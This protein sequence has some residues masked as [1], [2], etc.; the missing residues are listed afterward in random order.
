MAKTRN[1]WGL[2]IG[3]C[4]LKALKLTESEGVVQVDA[5]EIIEHAKI[6]SEPD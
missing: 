5:F 3:Q 4:A 2:D 1:V 6:L